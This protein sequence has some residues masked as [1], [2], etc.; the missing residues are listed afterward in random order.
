[1]VQ[2]AWAAGFATLVAV[3]GPSALAVDTARAA[4]MYLAGFVR[5]NTLRVYSPDD[6]TPTLLP[7]GPHEASAEERT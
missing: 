5:G 2:K 6:T 4:N 3:S 7:H 1:M